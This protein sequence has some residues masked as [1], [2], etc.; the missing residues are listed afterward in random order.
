MISVLALLGAVYLIWR[1]ELRRNTEG[2]PVND[3]N[4][5]D[6]ATNKNQC[7]GNMVR[8]I[9]IIEIDNILGTY[10]DVEIFAL[11]NQTAGRI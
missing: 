9:I 8:V 3:T 10:E 2:P 5:T 7:H 6:A 1:E 4:Q 11:I